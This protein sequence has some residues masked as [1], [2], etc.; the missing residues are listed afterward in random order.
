M[1]WADLRPFGAGILSSATFL[2]FSPQATNLRPF[3]AGRI[4]RFIDF[5][6]ILTG[7]E[8]EVCYRSLAPRV[9]LVEFHDARVTCPYNSGSRLVSR[10]NV[11]RYLAVHSGG[12]SSRRRRSARAW[13]QIITLVQGQEPVPALDLDSP[14]LIRAP[15]P[16]DR[17]LRA[18]I[19]SLTEKIGNYGPR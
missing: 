14:R 15:S 1:A 2:G 18:R 17:Q 7:G 12:R 4:P 10:A 19:E 5:A 11:C 3:G 9:L 13:R 8:H 16:Q 6:E